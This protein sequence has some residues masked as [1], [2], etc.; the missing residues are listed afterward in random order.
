MNYKPL[1]S[2]CLFTYNQEDFIEEALSSALNQTYSPLEIIIS[3][4]SSIDLT[5]QRISKIISTYTG[6]HKI[7]VNRNET[8]LGLVENVNKVIFDISKGDIIAMAAGDDI[9]LPQRIERSVEFLS[10]NSEL[11]AVSCG[12]T[13]I[14]H[15][16]KKIPNVNDEYNND[17]IF[18]IGDYLSN[19][20]FH[21]NGASRVIRKVVFDTFGPLNPDCPT[22]DS[23]ILLRCFI[24][25]KVGFIHDKLVKYRWHQNNMS[26][27]NNI[28][29][30]KTKKIFEQYITDIKNAKTKNLINR[31]LLKQLV[32]RSHTYKR[33]RYIKEI[34]YAIT[35]SKYYT[36]LKQFP[37]LLKKDNTIN[38]WWWS[39]K[40]LR[41][42]GDELSP[43]I[44]ERIFNVRI[45]NSKSYGPYY[46]IRERLFNKLLKPLSKLELH[47][48]IV[49][50]EIFAV[51]SVIRFSKKNTLVWGS[52]I[53][54][55]NDKILGGKF[56]AV[57]GYK[58]KKRLEELGLNP[59]DVMG[60]PALLMPLIYHPRVIKTKILGIIPHY[61]DIDMFSKTSEA[62]ILIIDLRSSN[63]EEVID[64]IIS[65]EYIISS[66]LHG[67]IVSHAY[68]IPALW[69]KF[70]QNISGDDIKFL[71]YFSSV[72]IKEYDPLKLDINNIDLTAILGTFE[73]YKEYS[74][75][76]I[77]LA[78]LQNRLIES[79]PFKKR[80]K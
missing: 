40:D 70:S 27:Y 80:S 65:C 75:I 67:L 56:L 57:R 24:L 42:F 9:S 21:I 32:K 49:P 74:T 47:Y 19:K 58:T 51:G 13:Y 33:I 3:D 16:S 6:P 68:N 37:L 12:L 79:A 26:T 2:F 77:D 23:T 52:G 55:K 30:L 31:T 50:K 46:N 53:I 54:D 8:N 29:K 18:S 1:V 64:K 59:P 22:E 39:E 66:S 38:L 60:D 61:V 76:K 36:I 20:E 43:Y 41:N 78:L 11:K 72:S 71:D 48:K 25:G 10:N 7:I 44:I 62:D 63:I 35:H 15:N 17:K 5:F 45:H 34:K 73:K 69:F 28:Y 14:N 4:D